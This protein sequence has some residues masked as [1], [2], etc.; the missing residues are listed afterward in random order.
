V[1]SSARGGGDGDGRSD[2]PFLGRIPLDAEVRIGG[3]GRPIVVTQP[4]ILR[5]S[6][7]EMARSHR[8][9]NY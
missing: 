5:L 9:I 2:V 7:S 3:Y 1:I 4:E 8:G 6:L